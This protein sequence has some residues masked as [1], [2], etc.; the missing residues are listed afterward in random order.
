M[1]Y[2]RIVELIGQEKLFALL[3]DPDKCDNTH[4]DSLLAVAN[5]CNVS[6]LLI[7]G[8]LVK[9]DMQEFLKNVKKRTS[10]PVILFPG[11][12]I[13]FSEGADA[14]LLLSLISGRN[15]D[16]L[17][18]NHILVSNAIKM[19]GIE[20]I[21]TGY[22]LVDGGNPTSVQYMSNTMPIPSTKIDIAVATALAGEQ[23]GLKMLYLEAGSGATNPVP[24]EMIRSVRNEIQIPLI[25]GG[26]L[27][28]P[29]QVKAAWGAGADIVVVGNALENDIS[30]LS[31]LAGM[32]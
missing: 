7:G 3:L 11:N 23:L 20:V 30:M 15:P 8:S 28:K 10:I 12:A 2:H 4:L 14:I 19:S 1:I 13:Q 21:P 24:V 26:G 25:V 22:M 6:M 27:K 5:K 31:V 9:S 18:G 32:K 17:I 29:E 16:F